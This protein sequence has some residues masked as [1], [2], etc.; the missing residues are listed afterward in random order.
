MR[1][2][3]TISAVVKIDGEAPTIRESFIVSES[4]AVLL[5]MGR[6][7]KTWTRRSCC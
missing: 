4:T 2:K 5:S 3:E 7:L 6:V 1:S